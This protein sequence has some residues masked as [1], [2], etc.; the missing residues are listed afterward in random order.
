MLYGR[1]AALEAARNKQ[2]AVHRLYKGPR[3]DPSVLEDIKNLRPDLIPTTVSPEQLDAT[4][5]DRAPH[6]NLLIEVSPLDQP[7]LLT[8]AGKPGPAL[9]LMLDQVTDPQNV[10]ACL[11]SA[12]AL[13]A[14]GVITQD[15]NSPGESGAL[16]RAASG[17]LETLP[18][19]RTPNLSQA[20]DML[21]GEG[22]W[23]VGLDGNGKDVI[24]SFDP[25][26]RVILV[27]GS[28]GRGIR[29]LVAKHCD[30]LARIPMTG[31]VESLNVSVAAAVA[32]FTLVKTD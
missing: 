17:A 6:Q 2:R 19:I 26:D 8:L 3:L 20:L 29:P 9:F 30:Y 32:M 18:W 25:G 15:R 31:L 23:S 7:P 1:N 28:E 13:G 12:A 16:A 11:R 14:R 27:M 21:S 10:G 24:G 4:F 5:P 22:F